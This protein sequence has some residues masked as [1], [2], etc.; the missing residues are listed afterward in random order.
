MVKIQNYILLLGIIIV[1]LIYSLSI[2]QTGPKEKC[3]IALKS[4][5]YTLGPYVSKKAGWVTK[6]KHV[7]NSNLICYIKD[8]KIHSI[9]DNGV[10]IAEGDF[11]GRDTLAERDRLNRER[12]EKIELTI[13]E[14]KQRINREYDTKIR[15]LKISSIPDEVDQFRGTD[16]K[17][18]KRDREAQQAKKDAEEKEAKRRAEELARQ[19]RQ[20]EIDKIKSQ[21]ANE[22][23]NIEQESQS[24][25]YKII[26]VDDISITTTR[27]LAYRIQLDDVYPEAQVVQIAEK[28]VKANHRGKDLV[29]ALKF[30]FYFPG[31]DPLSY[32]DGS[33]DWAPNGKW[34]AAHKVKKGNYATF[35]FIVKFY[36]YERGRKIQQILKNETIPKDT[37]LI[38]KWIDSGVTKIVYKDGK[39]FMERKFHDGSSLNQEITEKPSSKGRRFNSNNSFG[40][41]VIVLPNGKLSFY[42]GDGF[43]KTLS[44]AK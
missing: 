28:I 35:R 5:G 16:E 8:N 31:S 37:Q 36:Q 17:W 7:F 20:S 11:F 2:A 39:Y 32:A 3:S 21:T 41:Y 22:P 9:E 33:I 18:E 10:L 12:K 27:R 1:V 30:F 19:N 6:E 4:L 38:G 34:E 43:I 14:V 26:Q 15:N 23:I 25:K 44:I 42:D 24:I 40:E 29:N 13:E